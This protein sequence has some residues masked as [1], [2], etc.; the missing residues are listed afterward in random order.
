MRLNSRISVLSQSIAL[1]TSLMI[2]GTHAETFT[3]I[4]AVN[5]NVA[6]IPYFKFYLDLVINTYSTQNVIPV[7]VRDNNYLILKRELE[8]LEID[9]SKFTSPSDL[10]DDDLAQL[11]LDTL[12]ED[13]VKLEANG[14]GYSVKYQSQNQQLQLNLPTDWLPEQMLGKDYWYKQAPA[15]SGIGLLNNFDAYYYIPDQGGSA[16]NL[17]TEQRFF[18]PMGTLINSGIYSSIE[19]EQGQKKQNEYIRYDTTWRYDDENSIYTVE[20][21]DLYS[22][23][24]NSWA[25]SVRMGGIQIRKNYSIRP[26]LITYPLP[27]F[28]G[29]VGLPSTVDLFINGSK[30]ST[31]Q[32]QPGPFL[33]TNVPF[34]NGRGEAVIVTR[35]AVGRQVSTTVPFYVSGDLLKK[36]MF[37]Y[38]FS[39]G[40]LREN[41]GLKNFDYGD[42]VSSFD[43]RYGVNN[44]LTGEF[45]LEGNEKVWNAGVG[46]VITLKNFGVLNTSY[47]HSSV[48][49]SPFSTNSNEGDGH[50][51]TVGYQYQQSHFGFN[52]SHSRRSRNFSNLANYYS[53]TLSSVNSDESTNANV[54]ISGENTGT[55]GVGY[56]NIQRSNFENTELLSL[57]WAPVLPNF[58]EGASASISAN[59]DL[60]EKTWSAALQLS[61]P[62]GRTPSRINAGYQYQENGG[63]SSYLNYSYQMP[64]DGGFGVDL[65]HRFNERGDDFNQAQVR[66]RNRYLNF[67]AG[68]SGQDHYDQWYGLSGSFVWMKNSLFFSN[69]L[70][71]SFALVN[72]N[73]NA[74]I[75]IRYENNL[76]GKTNSKGY[77]F[78]P[79]VTPYYNGKYS[80]DP[81][82]LPSNYATPVIEQRVAA[83]LGTGIL[84]DFPVK[85]VTSASVY[86]KL[87]NGNPVPVG[88]IV[89][90]EGKDS[91]Y[92][93]M[94]G[95]AYIAEVD[96][97]NTLNVVLENGGSC[98][99]SFEAALDSKEIQSIENVL[100]KMDGDENE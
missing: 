50:Q 88:S 76:I 66:Y 74:D 84:V 59:Q 33:I 48:E 80:I 18:S 98:K 7:L 22:L 14:E 20:V 25:S 26:D 60:N 6:Q 13:W 75:P 40:K 85:K 63:N 32:L 99:A 71:E 95:I 79:N 62:L 4:P 82:N 24:K 92:V 43:S 10:T 64:T 52:A 91:T 65:T 83:K 57:S 100:C 16:F 37:D 51:F 56:F 73:K 27:Q 68:V 77:L 39:L 61:F 12:T 9:Y 78:V 41:Y 49:E 21:G 42:F 8:K 38:S 94:D 87:A 58:W 1:V 45:H 55:F 19:G 86:L 81:L 53:S 46:S 2:T 29:E 54:Y 67:D 44:W 72:T 31:E 69:R 5:T 35:D 70:G 90:Q 47:T 30:N 3:E 23:N 96:E 17:F 97:K 28:K 89:H 15:K 36:G 93:G 11:G 34:I